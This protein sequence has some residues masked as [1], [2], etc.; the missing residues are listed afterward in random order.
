MSNTNKNNLWLTNKTNGKYIKIKQ[1][2]GGGHEQ[3]PMVKQWG[4]PQKATKTVKTA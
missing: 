3:H 1:V 4:H 2:S